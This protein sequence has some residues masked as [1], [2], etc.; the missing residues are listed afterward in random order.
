MLLPCC[1]PCDLE[2]S[3]VS[4]LL[5][6]INNNGTEKEKP[7][8]SQYYSKHCAVSLKIYI[9]FNGA[10]RWMSKVYIF[11]FVDH[12]H[13]IMPKFHDFSSCMVLT[14]WYLWIIDKPCQWAT[15]NLIY[16][17]GVI[18]STVQPIHNT[19]ENLCTLLCSRVV[20]RLVN[21]ILTSVTESRGP[22]KKIK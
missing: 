13:L 11:I 5:L 15:C 16:Y 6:V 19:K 14:N 3:L 9:D 2:A 18:A 10:T 20:S 17:H 8:I 22:K 21:F 12:Q 7:S 4:L 1:I